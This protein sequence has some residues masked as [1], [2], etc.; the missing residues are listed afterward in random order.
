VIAPGSH[1]KML[2]VE[3]DFSKNVPGSGKMHSTIRIKADG[4]DLERN[5][6]S[7]GPLD[8]GDAIIFHSLLLH[9]SGLNR[10]NRSRL[11]M[12]PRYAD[13]LDPAFVGRGWRAVRDKTP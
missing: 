9:R 6:L 1:K 5:A 8:A 3:M 4:R 7:V 12:N 10:S 11:I 13:A 2:P